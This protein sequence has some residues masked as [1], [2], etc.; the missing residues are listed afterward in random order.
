M[1][2][3]NFHV[4]SH[5]SCYILKPPAHSFLLDPNV[6]LRSQFS[7]TV[8]Y[9]LRFNWRSNMSTQNKSRQ[10]H[11]KRPLFCCADA[12]T[13]LISPG[14]VKYMLHAYLQTNV[15]YHIK[16]ADRHIRTPTPQYQGHA[17]SCWCLYLFTHTNYCL[18]TSSWSFL[19]ESL[20]FVISCC[21]GKVAYGSWK[22][23]NVAE[24]STSFDVCKICVDLG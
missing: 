15:S 3:D 1:F 8:K 6:T 7:D 5:K 18:R 9:V 19:P 22:W 11:L 23:Q 14:N 4:W 24:V 13:L 20:C 21:R 10:L 12:I 17:L 2:D 16:P